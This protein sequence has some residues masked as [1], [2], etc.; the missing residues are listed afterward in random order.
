MRHMLKSPFFWML[1]VCLAIVVYCDISAAT[2]VNVMYDAMWPKY[3]SMPHF[4]GR[5]LH[6]ISDTSAIYDPI[7]PVAVITEMVLFLIMTVVAAVA[8]C[9]LWLLSG[10]VVRKVKGHQS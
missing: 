2:G 10:V 9:P 5:A 3:E 1:S 4:W 6:L 8:V 7:T